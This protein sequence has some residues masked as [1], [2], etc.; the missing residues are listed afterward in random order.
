MILQLCD[1]EPILNIDMHW[2]VVKLQMRTCFID[3]NRRKTDKICI[4]KKRERAKN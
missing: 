3:G 2:I 4:Y 1:Y